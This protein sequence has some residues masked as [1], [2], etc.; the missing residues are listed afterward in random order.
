[1]K[2]WA[3]I[4]KNKTLHVKRYFDSYDLYEAVHSP[5]VVHMHGPFE[6]QNRSDA[7]RV[8]LRHFKGGQRDRGRKING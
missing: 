2:W 4:H 1:M 7:E 6:A 5:F 3:Y 8:A